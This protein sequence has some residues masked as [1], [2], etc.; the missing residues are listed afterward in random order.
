MEC[1]SAVHYVRPLDHEERTRRDPHGPLSSPFHSEPSKRPRPVPRN[2]ERKWICRMYAYLRHAMR[3]RRLQICLGF[4]AQG[5]DSCPARH[6]EPDNLL[7][8]KQIKV[9]NYTQYGL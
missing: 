7:R 8:R 6:C 2:V 5:V 9:V 3:W 4:G 1:S